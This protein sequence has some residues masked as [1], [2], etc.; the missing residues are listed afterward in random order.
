MIIHKMI[1]NR[2]LSIALIGFFAFA[3][4]SGAA[5]DRGVNIAKPAAISP[6]LGLEIPMNLGVIE[7]TYKGTSA[8]PI[9]F[10]R[11]IPGSETAHK[12]IVELVEHLIAKQGAKAIFVGEYKGNPLATG[13]TSA[14]DSALIE[15]ATKFFLEKLRIGGFEYSFIKSRAIFQLFKRDKGQDP[16]LVVSCKYKKKTVTKLMK[17][18]KL[19]YLVVSPQLPENEAHLLTENDIAFGASRRAVGFVVGTVFNVVAIPPVIVGRILF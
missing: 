15:K 11:N 4:V 8:F 16:S 10:I 18:K 17:K 9:V 12:K 3:S 2:V 6:M 13:L 14:K 5:L 1:V 7:E 19:S